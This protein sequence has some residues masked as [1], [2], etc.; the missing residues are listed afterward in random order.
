MKKIYHVIFIV[1]ISMFFNG[2]LRHIPEVP[3]AKGEVVNLDITPME[4]EKAKKIFQ[5]T[6]FDYLVS[7]VWKEELRYSNH[8]TFYE[9][10]TKDYDFVGVQEKKSPTTESTLFLYESK[11]F[12]FRKAISVFSFTEKSRAKAVYVKKT[13]RYALVISDSQVNIGYGAIQLTFIGSYWRFSH[14][15]AF[16]HFSSNLYNHTKDY[17]LYNSRE[18]PKENTHDRPI[19]LPFL[20]KEDLDNF[21]TVFLGTF[22]I[23]KVE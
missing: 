4:T 9:N 18:I 19:V 14:P 20:T 23:I 11:T 22:P 17:M 8:E 13:N 1:V 7:P 10:V 2:C 16:G 5:K 21:A 12:S 15:N 6:F 3:E